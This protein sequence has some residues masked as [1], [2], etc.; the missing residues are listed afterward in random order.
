M[1][2]LPK[3]RKLPP[4]KEQEAKRRR[5]RFDA[6]Y[7]G[8]ITTGEG[9]RDMFMLECKKPDGQ[10][11]TY[12]TL[13]G[14]NATHFPV[15]ITSN[16]KRHI[17]C[18]PFFGF[19]NVFMKMPMAPM[20]K[21]NFINFVN[22]KCFNYLK[23]SLNYDIVHTYFTDVGKI[24]NADAEKFLRIATQNDID[25][26]KT[27]IGSSGFAETLSLYNA[28]VDDKLKKLE[29]GSMGIHNISIL[30]LHAFIG[31]NNMFGV[32]LA[33]VRLT[34]S[35]L[36]EI[37]GKPDLGTKNTLYCEY[38]GIYDPAQVL[39]FNTDLEKY[40]NRF[41]SNKKNTSA[42]IEYHRKI[43]TPPL[44]AILIEASNAFGQ[45]HAQRQDTYQDMRTRANIAK[46]IADKISADR[47]IKYHLERYPPHVFV[48]YQQPLPQPLPQSLPQPPPQ[49]LPQPLPQH[50]FV[51][52]QQPLSQP[53]PHPLPQPQ[54]SQN[55]GRSESE[56]KRYYSAKNDY[57]NMR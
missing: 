54:G 23:Q 43:D 53:L 33:D 14:V 47:E 11:Y 35:I 55:G 49:S 17:R 25:D 13:S 31:T 19:T 24:S 44:G 37:D 56:M 1:S 5:I 45:R 4:K 41:I 22:Q 48:P 38:F 3:K 29:N 36:T 27:R 10:N 57:F 9:R 8:S 39:V 34:S 16:G 7:I 51:P 26:I 20:V 15:Y 30:E 21:P 46:L 50:V 18:L 12:P 6:E 28:D 40:R 32:S 2:Q 52:Y 42:H